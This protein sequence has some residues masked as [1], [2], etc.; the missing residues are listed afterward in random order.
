MVEYNF[1]EVAVLAHVLACVELVE[2]VVV[3]EGQHAKEGS[4]RHVVSRS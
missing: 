1:L 4:L 2:I 3:E